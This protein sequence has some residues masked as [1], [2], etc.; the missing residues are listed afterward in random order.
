MGTTYIFIMEGADVDNTRIALSPL[1]INLLDGKKVHSTHVCD[2]NM[3]GL[4]MVL[5]G[6]IV[7]SLMI[8]SLIGIRPLCKVGCKV[9]FNN[10]KCGVIFNGKIVLTWHKDP[11]T[12]LWTL[13]IPIGRMLTTP[14]LVTLSPHS[15]QMIL[16]HQVGH[17]D[18][19]ATAMVPG[20]LSPCVIQDTF[21]MVLPLPQPGHCIGHAPHP[22]QMESNIHPGINLAPFAH[23]VQTQANAVIFAHQSLCNPK[24]STLLKAT[25]KGSSKGAH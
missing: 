22:H 25:Q 7:L 14:S 13:P 2:I 10:K 23:L 21:K 4:T 9:I 12:D 15:A 18:E 16:S 5:T 19:P 6:H 17:S 3:P 8:P 24:I 11:S 20:K 1:T